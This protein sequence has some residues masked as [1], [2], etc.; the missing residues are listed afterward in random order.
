MP[1]GGRET[2]FIHT[3]ERVVFGTRVRHTTITGLWYATE[4]TIRAWV[5]LAGLGCYFYSGLGGE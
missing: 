4:C 3:S 2:T 5:F 1:L